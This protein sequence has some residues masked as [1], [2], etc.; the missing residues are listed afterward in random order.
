MGVGRVG[1]DRGWVVD[2]PEIA[3]VHESMVVSSVGVS[4]CLIER[5]TVLLLFRGLVSVEVVVAPVVVVVVVLVARVT[6]C[7]G[8]TVECRP[9]CWAAGL[10]SG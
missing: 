9:S 1:V 5:G 6:V 3:L 8:S 2:G 10:A 7:L 4:R